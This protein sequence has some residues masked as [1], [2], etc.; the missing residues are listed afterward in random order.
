MGSVHVVVWAAVAAGDMETRDTAR[1]AALQSGI[2]G[3]GLSP[4]H[5]YGV[6]CFPAGI[7]GGDV[8][9]SAAD[10]NSWG[11]P[12]GLDGNLLRVGPL[13]LSPDDGARPKPSSSID[14]HIA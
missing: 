7:N 2:L 6:Y 8:I 12:L 4:W 1:S 5:V 14:G 11:R 9:A 10:G 3:V 13:Y